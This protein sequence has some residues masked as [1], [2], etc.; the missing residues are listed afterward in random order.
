MR[1]AKVFHI[2]FSTKNIGEFYI[3]IFENLTKRQ[4]A[5]SLV[6]NNQAQAVIITSIRCSFLYAFPV[7]DCSKVKTSLV[8]I[9]L[10]FQTLRLIYF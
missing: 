10:K 4:L 8:N 9:S 3:L 2:F 6:L 5:M 7:P 1:E